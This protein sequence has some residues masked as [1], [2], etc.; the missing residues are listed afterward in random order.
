MRVVLLLL[1]CRLW[2][3]LTVVHD[4]D[5]WRELWLLLQGHILLEWLLMRRLSVHAGR[6]NQRRR[7]RC[8]CCWCRGKL[9]DVGSHC[10][11]LL[12][13]SSQGVHLCLQLI[14]SGLA[15]QFGPTFLLS[16]IG[17]QLLFVHSLSLTFVEFLHLFLPFLLVTLW[18]VCTVAPIY[19]QS[20][21]YLTD[22]ACRLVR[23]QVDDG[24]DSVLDELNDFVRNLWPGN[25]ERKSDSIK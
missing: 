4:A 9:N 6:C 3:K 14:V 11:E 10:I 8:S 22:S 20:P 7:R 12:F 16:N 18:N 5:Q 17:V 21:C 24:D 15:L 13:R 1:C 2:M 23:T 19:F 25:Q